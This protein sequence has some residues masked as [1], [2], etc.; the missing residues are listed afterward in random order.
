[1][2]TAK[3]MFAIP[4]NALPVADVIHELGGVLEDD[5]DLMVYLA[6]NPGA[7]TSVVFEDSDDPIADVGAVTD[8]LK[9]AGSRYFAVTDS[10]TERS[11]NTRFSAHVFLNLSGTPDGEKSAKFPWENGEPDVNE[12]TLEEAG[13]A[14]ADVKAMTEAFFPDSPRSIHWGAR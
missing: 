1:M 10:Y 3:V 11:R 4:E 13:F 12:Q 6:A 9:A 2:P 8:L 14:A 7:L 5:D